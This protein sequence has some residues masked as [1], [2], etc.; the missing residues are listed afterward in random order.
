MLQEELAQ[1]VKLLV[2]LSI[3]VPT[4]TGRHV[5]RVATQKDGGRGY[6][7]QVR[8]E[9]IWARG[10]EVGLWKTLMVRCVQMTQLSCGPRM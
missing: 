8:L 3:R 1:E 7:P 4:F 6:M 2:Y 10:K 9:G 5:L